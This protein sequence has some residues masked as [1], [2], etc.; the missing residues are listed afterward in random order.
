MAEDGMLGFQREI[1]D[2]ESL[3]ALG[4]LYG[5]K[6]RRRRRGGGAGSRCR[7]HGATRSQLLHLPTNANKDA[8]RKYCL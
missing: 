2:A 3:S 7:R 1:Q 4:W 5:A 6:S 8:G